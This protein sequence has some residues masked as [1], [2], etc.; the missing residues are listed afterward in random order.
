MSTRQFFFNLTFAGNDS[1]RDVAF[2]FL[3]LQQFLMQQDGVKSLGQAAKS[4]D[5]NERKKKLKLKISPHVTVYHKVDTFCVHP[6]LSL[7]RTQTQLKTPFNIAE[8]F[9][10]VTALHNLSEDGRDR[11]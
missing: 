1:K 3:M 11:M 5:Q 8:T 6:S 7:A 4:L 2:Q 10:H 9:Y